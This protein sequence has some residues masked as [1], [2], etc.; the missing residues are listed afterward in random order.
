MLEKY[1]SRDFEGNVEFHITEQ[2]AKDSAEDFI[3]E[4]LSADFGWDENVTDIC[5]GKIEIKQSAVEENR[6]EDPDGIFDYIVD[7]NL[8]DTLTPELLEDK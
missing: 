4:A 5:W 7:Y 2:Q 6:R 8:R 1:F 3:Q